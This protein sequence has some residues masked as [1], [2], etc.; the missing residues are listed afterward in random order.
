MLGFQN[1]V[2]GH[3]N[4]VATLTWFSYIKMKICQDKKDLPNNN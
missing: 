1:V 4:R 3:I 2:L